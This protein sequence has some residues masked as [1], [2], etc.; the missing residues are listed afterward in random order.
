MKSVFPSQNA[1]RDL[2]G[3]FDSGDT[4]F[5]IASNSNPSSVVQSPFG[6]NPVLSPV[7]PISGGSAGIYRN[8]LDDLF[9]GGAPDVPLSNPLPS[10]APAPVPM[11]LQSFGLSSF[12]SVGIPSLSTVPSTA[13]NGTAHG[14][15]QFELIPGQFFP[16]TF[17]TLPKAEQLSTLWARAEQDG[18]MSGKLW[19]KI[20]FLYYA[21][22]SCA[23]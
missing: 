19:L 5:G 18:I 1:F 9:G 15:S 4:D 17:F 8:E 16:N 23:L 10:F 3:G 12:S 2:I 21:A 20:I 14:H 6:G 22:N 7:T 13:L 11:G